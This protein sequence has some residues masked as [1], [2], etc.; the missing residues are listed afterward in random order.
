MRRN[1]DN[2]IGLMERQA[3]LNRPLCRC[4]VMYLGSSV[5]HITKNGLHGIQEPLRQ[6]YPEKQFNASKLS[7]MAHNI[8]QPT[9]SGTIDISHLSD[10]LGIDSWLSVWSNGL[11]LENVDEFGCEIRR[12]FSIESL[13]YCA[14][15]RFF[16][17]ATLTGE[18]FAGRRAAE[19][20]ETSDL[21]NNN[22]N[23]NVETNAT[24][25]D[26]QTGEEE[27]QPASGRQVTSRFLPLDA[28]LFQVPGMLDPSHPP[29]FAAIMRRTSGI[30]VLECHAFI[31]R[32]DAAANALVRCCTHSYADLLNA[33][34]LSLELCRQTR[35]TPRANKLRVGAPEADIPGGGHD[36]ETRADLTYEPTAMLSGKSANAAHSTG[37]S[38]E[39]D[40][41]LE[42]SSED[43]YAIISK[44]YQAPAGAGA[45]TPSE[46]LGGAALEPA[47]SDLNPYS[48][49]KRTSELG[50]KTEQ[51]SANRKDLS[52]T[53]SLFDDF[54]PLVRDAER[55]QCGDLSQQAKLSH[56]LDMLE[57]SNAPT[58][59]DGLPGTCGSGAPVE[60]SLV[61]SRAGQRKERRHSKSMQNLDG[62]LEFSAAAARGGHSERRRERSRQRRRTSFSQKSRKAASC[63]DMM[64]PAV[65]WP[66]AAAAS[67]AAQ[68]E[69]RLH[70]SG[71]GPAPPVPETDRRDRKAAAKSRQQQST[72]S[73]ARHKSRSQ[74]RGRHQAPVLLANHLLP[75]QRSY[76]HQ[77]TGY[78]ALFPPLPVGGGYPPMACYLPATAAAGPY[79]YPAGGYDPAYLG[80]FAPASEPFPPPHLQQQHQQQ[81]PFVGAS[82]SAPKQ[83]KTAT[84]SSLATRFRCL[85]PP[86]NFLRSRP[87]SQQVESSGPTKPAD[88][89]CPDGQVISGEPGFIA[90]SQVAG[91]GARKKMGWIKRLSLTMAS[92]GPS[93]APAGEPPQQQQVEQVENCGEPQ[94]QQRRNQKKQAAS[95][96]FGSLTLGR[97]SKPKLAIASS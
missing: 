32:R 66:E 5:P 1:K 8:N 36:E 52:S 26:K 73:S 30:K 16:D 97:S 25:S 24:L 51:K 41:S 43:N 13:H 21:N 96:F 76:Y 83:R 93:A 82:V 64:A 57:L 31:C 4:R 35:S 23:N 39:T 67:S 15:V 29:V 78:P 22:N 59:C 33:K 71:S 20:D 94:L 6:L 87:S 69:Q 86:V 92:S 14:A 74:Q 54:M 37:T 44:H 80:A 7:P 61:A 45:A 50:A 9:I 95:T 28:P 85:S 46:P 79:P 90:H 55:E 38:N 68:L 49:P 40:H 77:P 12:F 18:G 27:E 63:Q 3:S 48:T 60:R 81:G 19:T 56:S 17:T 91:S 34:R 47:D 53:R 62:P 65:D 72:V 88:N 42:A 58:C 11:L 70:E 2:L 75:G 84:R 89:D 10:S